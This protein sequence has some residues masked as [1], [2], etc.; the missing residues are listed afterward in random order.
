MTWHIP[1]Q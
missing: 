1:I